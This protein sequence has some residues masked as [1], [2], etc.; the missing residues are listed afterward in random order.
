MIFAESETNASRIP[1]GGRLRYYSLYLPGDSVEVSLSISTNYPAPYPNPN[2]PNK[3]PNLN[4]NPS[5]PWN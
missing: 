4:L 5:Y 3:L 2:H 1:P